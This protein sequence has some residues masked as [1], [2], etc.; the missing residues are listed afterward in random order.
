MTE[1]STVA[2]LGLA[3][4]LLSY[5]FVLILSWIRPFFLSWKSGHI[6]VSGR[7]GEL[8][9]QIDGIGRSPCGLVQG[10]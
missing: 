10:S 3:N 1:R 4:R 6:E 7:M 2:A 9:K 8:R 5:L